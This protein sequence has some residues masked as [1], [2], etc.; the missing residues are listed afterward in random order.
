[1]GHITLPSFIIRWIGVLI[2]PPCHPVNDPLIHSHLVMMTTKEQRNNANSLQRVGPYSQSVVPIYHIISFH[3]IICFLSHKRVASLLPSYRLTSFTQERTEYLACEQKGILVWP[4]IALPE[5]S[6]PSL[7]LSLSRSNS[8]FTW[9]TNRQTHTAIRSP[10]QAA[11][12]GSS[13]CSLLCSPPHTTKSPPATLLRHSMNR[14]T[15]TMTKKKQPVL[16]YPQVNISF[17]KRTPGWIRMLDPDMVTAK[18]NQAKK[19]PQLSH[20]REK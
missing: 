15:K 5:E 16:S 2:F 9:Q 8:W 7:S 20:L 1:M 3:S 12:W 18:M 17:T 10:I 14:K 13:P 6:P 11:I 19:N 4:G